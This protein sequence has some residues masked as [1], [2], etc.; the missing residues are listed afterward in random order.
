MKTRERRPDG[1]MVPEHEVKQVACQGDVKWSVGQSTP[2]S[3]F[4]REEADMATGERVKPAVGLSSGWRRSLRVRH[5]EL[6]ED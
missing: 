4:D 2:Y 5:P 3:I 1:L 6:L